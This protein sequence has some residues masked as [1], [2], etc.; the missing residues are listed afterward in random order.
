MKFAVK[1]VLD[2]TLI[3]L[4][5]FVLPSDQLENTYPLAGVAVTL[6]V[7]PCSY[8]PPVVDTDPPL[9]A[10]IVTVYFVF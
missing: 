6:T 8:D 5:A 3:V 7:C 4:V 9:P 1:F 2:E 10:D